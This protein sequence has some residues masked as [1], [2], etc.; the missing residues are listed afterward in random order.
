MLQ[1][2]RFFFVVFVGASALGCHSRMPSSP[3]VD[4]I[5]FTTKDDVFSDAFMDSN[6][7]RYIRPDTSLAIEFELKSYLPFPGS[8]VAQYATLASP[9]DTVLY[10]HFY[11]TYKDGC[12]GL[13]P[14]RSELYYQDDCAASGFVS[15]AQ[16]RLMR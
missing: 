12:E 10:Y 5:F 2:T 13:P 3:A 6:D 15:K 14:N 4:R 16:V 1:V 7:Y 8:V 9:Q 11:Y